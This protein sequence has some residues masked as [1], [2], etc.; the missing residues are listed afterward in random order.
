MKNIAQLSEV[1][2]IEYI[3]K[4]KNFYTSNG[5]KGKQ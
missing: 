2:D 1:R 5:P 4:V 3:W